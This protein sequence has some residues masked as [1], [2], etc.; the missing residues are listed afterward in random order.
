MFIKYKEVDNTEVTEIEPYDDTIVYFNVQEY[1]Y[2]PVHV[3]ITEQYIT[4]NAKYISAVDGSFDISVLSG[5][6]RDKLS[7]TALIKDAVSIDNNLV[8]TKNW[9][10]QQEMEAALYVVGDK[11]IRV[12]VVDKPRVF[13][14]IIN[15]LK[16]ENPV[17]SKYTSLNVSS[18]TITNKMRS[19]S[20][21]PSIT[22]GLGNSLTKVYALNN[23][24]DS[25]SVSRELRKFEDAI[26]VY[27]Q[28]VATI[29]DCDIADYYYLTDNI[30]YAEVGNYVI[31]IYKVN[32][33]TVLTCYGYGD[34]A[35]DNTVF[36][37]TNQN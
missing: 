31:G 7:E 37:L 11:A 21:T 20:G 10:K 22:A 8:V 32:Y 4:D 3:P 36:F 19:F 1:T 35:K 25:L 33:N 6:N 18:S 14:T 5:I 13:A 29:A 12:H 23:G 30:F 28:R 34:S 26:D 17:T 24:N 15:G 2:F 16:S 27:S 9:Q